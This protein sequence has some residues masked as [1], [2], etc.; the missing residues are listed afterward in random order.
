MSL[1]NFSLISLTPL[2]H[3]L[4]LFYQSRSR[5]STFILRHLNSFFLQYVCFSL[6]RWDLSKVLGHFKMKECIW[7][8][9]Q[10]HQLPNSHWESQPF[11]LLVRMSLEG[12][13][14]TLILG[15]LLLLAGANFLHLCPKGNKTPCHPVC[16]ESLQQ[17]GTLLHQ[18]V[19]SISNTVLFRFF[20]LTIAQRK[21]CE[22]WAGYKPR[23]CYRLTMAITKRT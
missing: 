19:S 21:R 16:G 20:Q 3:Q 5:L 11:I 7:A 4:P 14:H 23:D 22:W 8:N 13:F 6:P 1:S 18:T 12:S 9:I 10:K 17:F 15:S 2:N